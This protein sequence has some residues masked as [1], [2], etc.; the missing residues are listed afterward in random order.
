L[1]Y[2]ADSWKRKLFN[3]LAQVI[4]QSTGGPGEIIFTAKSGDL[5]LG[6]LKINAVK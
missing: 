4:V 6:E 3:G 5:T 2:P 1:I